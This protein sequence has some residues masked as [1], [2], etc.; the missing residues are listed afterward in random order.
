[1]S[2]K[3]SEISLPVRA[4]IV[5]FYEKGESYREIAKKVKFSFSAVRYV[6]Q[7]FQATNSIGN[8]SRSG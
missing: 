4:R 2:P 7:R 1:M 6:I 8:E 5:T 3:T